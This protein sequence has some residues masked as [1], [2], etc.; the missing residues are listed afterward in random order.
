[1]F[2]EY[3]HHKRTYFHYYNHKQVQNKLSSRVPAAKLFISV[4]TELQITN[5]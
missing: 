5:R 4:A 1:M 3:Y 2:P